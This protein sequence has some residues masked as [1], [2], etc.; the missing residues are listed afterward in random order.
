DKGFVLVDLDRGRWEFRTIETRPMYDLGPVVF[1]GGTPDEVERE[2]MGLLESVDLEG[3]L[4]RVVV[5]DIP[6]SV[7]RALD[8]RRL[9]AAGADALHFQMGFTFSG[10]DVSLG[11]EGGTIGTVDLE[12]EE[13]MKE[14]PVEHLDRKRLAEMGRS[15]LH[16]PGGD[17]E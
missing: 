9:K 3:A 2:I 8:H 1:Q 12:F 11:G 6:R 10:D 14:Y 17:G 5:K 15:Y 16:S 13:F 7:Y 4:V